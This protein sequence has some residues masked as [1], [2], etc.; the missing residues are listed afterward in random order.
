MMEKYFLVFALVSTLAF[1]TS[2]YA[3]GDDTESA[4]PLEPARFLVRMASEREKLVQYC[5]RCRIGR[6]VSKETILGGESK[7]VRTLVFEYSMIDDHFIVIEYEGQT[8]AP[9]K[10]MKVSW[11]GRSGS[12]WIAG[13]NGRSVITQFDKQSIPMT[14]FDL[15]GIGMGFCG[16]FLNRTS[17]ES[18]I[19]SR[20]SLVDSPDPEKLQVLPN[21]LY[22]LVA[23]SV[24][25]SRS[26]L[27]QKKDSGQS[28][29][30]L[31]IRR[32]LN[33]R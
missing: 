24:M 27:I 28:K 20:K 30:S 4:I 2:R 10:N 14:Y 26:T 25:D 22:R 19:A 5:C 15:R 18:M 17:L 8:R 12:Y 7:G 9:T 1:S 21:G 29:A 33:G 23:Q 13:E 6:N 32:D 16:D 31:P 3:F 11:S